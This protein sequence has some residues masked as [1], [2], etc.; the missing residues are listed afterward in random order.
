LLDAVQSSLEAK[1]D[2]DEDDQPLLQKVRELH[3]SM[4]DR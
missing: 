4:G 1:S 2:A 3:Q